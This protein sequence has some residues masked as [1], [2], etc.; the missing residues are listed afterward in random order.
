MISFSRSLR[1]QLAGSVKVITLYPPSVD[2]AMM[3]GVGLP[4]ISTEACNRE[5]MK[6]LARDEDEIWIGEARYIPILSRLVP[7]QI[8]RIVNK[9]AG[10]S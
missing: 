2:T 10:G 4:T 8:F 6:R 5:I 9:A 1:H 3:A 7:R